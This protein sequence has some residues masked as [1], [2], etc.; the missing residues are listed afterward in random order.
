MIKVAPIYVFMMLFG[1]I[2]G[3]KPFFE[4]IFAG[5]FGYF[6]LYF[7]FVMVLRVDWWD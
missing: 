1:A 6:F 2:F 5:I 4:V 7:I 3:P